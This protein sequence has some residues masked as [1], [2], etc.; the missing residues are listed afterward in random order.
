[1]TLVPSRRH[2]TDMHDY[3]DSEAL[4]VQQF[5]QHDGVIVKV[6]VIDGQIYVSTRPSFMN[7]T[8]ETGK[9]ITYDSSIKNRPLPLSLYPSHGV[10]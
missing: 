3:N 5:I 2:L 8:E 9:P 6:Y 10:F 4:V 1:M 7:V